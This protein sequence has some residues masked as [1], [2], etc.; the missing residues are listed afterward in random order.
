MSDTPAGGR[1]GLGV[2][3]YS[4]EALSLVWTTSRPLTFAF[5]VLT[6]VAGLLPAA[7]A[8]VGQLIVDAVVAA[9][10]EG[11]SADEAIRYII[12]EGALFLAITAAQRGI[13]LCQSLLRAQ[14]GHRVN[15]L[16]LE[17]ALTL[18][19]SQ[20]E[21]ASFYDKLT[22]ARREA[23]SRPLSLV[24]RTFALAQNAVSLT[25]Y[26]VLL[27]QFSVWAVV[28]LVV[29]G[30]PAFLAETKFSGDAFRLFRWRS[31][32]SRMQM[33]LET[34]LAR[35]DHAKEV[36]LFRLGPLL[37][38]RYRGIFSRLFG[39][40]RALTIRRE[41]WGLILGTIGIVAFYATYG[42]IAVAT[43]SGQ[44]TLGEMTMYLL[45]FRQGQSAVAASLSAISGMY[46]D[47]L[48]LSNLY[49]YLDQPAPVATGTRTEGVDPADGIRIEN[50]S[51]TYP[52]ADQPA[53]EDIDLAVRP[54]ESLA[55][56]GENGAG[57]TTLTK[58]LTG[59][60]APDAGRILLDGSPLAEWDEA[61]LLSRFGVI[62]QDFTRYQLPVGENI[63]AGDVSAF[64]DEARWRE[65]AA[66]GMAAPF[67]ER[68]PAGY[69]T[70]LGRW[71]A[72]GQEL[73]VGQWQKM[74]LARAFMRQQADI[75][76]FDEPT[77]AMDAAA[78]AELFEHFRK[79]T[80]DK[81][82]ILIS[83]RFSTVRRADRIA[84][85]DGGRITEYGTHETLMTEGGRYATLF[86]LQAEG[87]R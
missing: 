57:K 36:K 46:E 14:L 73:S 43:V 81:V 71:F 7:M 82:T 22:R 29:A 11:G 45:V 60:Y 68:M 65:A 58:L 12:I 38:E 63:G 1:F 20:F 77:A 55:L 3:A 17:K 47:N 21:D 13:S 75:L 18:S 32:D 8:W 70:Q 53:L 87:Y 52:D 10:Q 83:H 6:L 54:G 39:E 78:E 26:A 51:F 62:F 59:L 64:D 19:M 5:G 35:E 27:V 86:T 84:V 56:V 72:K 23:S 67:I 28:I 15:V 44:I 40:D 74:A 24:N 61:A 30:L 33:Y 42:W 31:P 79:L 48:Y 69:E 4:R 37:L 16:I 85:I 66:Q 25:S 76:I 34:V 80:R 50:L 9:L 49:E 41:S 2:L